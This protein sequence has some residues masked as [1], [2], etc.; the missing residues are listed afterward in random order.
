MKKKL[1]VAILALTAALCCAFGLA[2]CSDGLSKDQKKLLQIEI[3]DSKSQ[4]EELLGAP[5]DKNN[6]YKWEYFGGEYASLNKQA[7]EI[8]EKMDFITNEKELEKYL[9]QLDEL[10]EKMDNLEYPYTTIFFDE[11]G[12]VSS[13]T[14]NANYSKNNRNDKKEFNN[15][16]LSSNIITMYTSLYS[17]GIYAKITYTDGSYKCCPIEYAKDFNSSNSGSIPLEWE[18][19]WG[20]YTTEITVTELIKKNTVIQDTISDTKFSATAMETGNIKEIKFSVVIQATPTTLNLTKKDS[21]W[22]SLRQYFNDVTIPDSVTEI[23]DKVFYNCSGLTSIVIPEKVTTIGEEAF[24]GC[25]GITNI[26]IPEKVTAIGNK[27]FVDCSGLSSITVDADNNTYYS[28]NDCLIEKES[29]TLI[30]GC[31]NSVIPNNITEIENYAFYNCSELTSII[32]PENVKT[33]GF[34]A[35][36][37][38][39]GLSSINVDSNNTTFYSENN[40]LIQKTKR[41]TT[42]FLGCKN[43]IIP[44]SVTTIGNNSFYNCKGLKSINIPDSVTYIGKYAFYGCSDLTNVTIPNSVTG[45]GSSAFSFC[46][47]LTSVTIPDSVTIIEE[48]TFGFCSSLTNITIPNSVTEICGDAFHDCTSIKSIVLPNSITKIGTQAFIGCTGLTNIIIPNSVT[49]I[50]DYSFH[51]CKGLTSITIPNSVKTVGAGAFEYCTGLTSIT[52]PDSV[53]EIGDYAFYGCTGLTSITIPDSIKSLSDYMF[54]YCTGLTN[55]SIPKVTAIGY[56]TFEYCENLTSITFNGTK[57]EWNELGEF[58]LDKAITVH[59]TD[60]DLTKSE[61]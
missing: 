42:L 53:T 37:G 48:Y 19:E 59:C 30:L 38:C 40:C 54:K 44:N 29:N 11:K 43:S 18:D 28:E 6:G 20:T 1:L 23:G 27:A 9:R 13:V 16:T 57:S 14:H 41:A 49:E 26:S 39:N 46:T 52:I 12:C 10:E 24:Y 47:G 45:I 15:I 56:Y 60:G 32:I 7:Q 22:V 2:A 3:G 8:E 61:S 51:G 36:T 34:D 5:D 58:F 33:I 31:K 25:S 50:A 4:V 17:A 55:V 35:F 21:T